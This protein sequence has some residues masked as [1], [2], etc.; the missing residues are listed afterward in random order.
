MLKFTKFVLKPLTR[1]VS[2]SVSKHSICSSL[3][4]DFIFDTHIEQKPKTTIQ[5]FSDVKLDLNKNFPRVSVCAETLIVSG[6]GNPSG[7]NFVN[8]FN[9]LSDSFVKI[10]FVPGE[11]EYGCNYFEKSKVDVGKKIL[12]DKMSI[13]KNIV[14]LDNQIHVLNNNIVVAGSTLWQYPFLDAGLVA[15]S[16]TDC[17]IR[18]IFDKNI[19]D[20]TWAIDQIRKNPYKHIVIATAFPPTSKGIQYGET[21]LLASR[22]SREN[23]T[24]TM[25]LSINWISG[26][27]HRNWNFGIP[28][29][30]PFYCNPHG[31]NYQNTSSF[32]TSATIEI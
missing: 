15:N 31:Y 19:S 24:Y 16:K 25:N 1:H 5:Y 18:D 4:N 21:N 13:Y 17:K 32:I 2:T 20:N 7:K 30:C 23:F 29:S 27:P 12:A 3:A 9:V 8:F 14:I 22:L 28:L 11:A 10:L 6:I 26:N